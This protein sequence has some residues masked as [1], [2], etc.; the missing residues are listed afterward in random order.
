V[1]TARQGERRLRRG[2][3]IAA[4]S[5]LLLVGSTF[6]QWFGAEPGPYNTLQLIVLLGYG[7]T[8]WQ[9]LDLLP[10]FLT[11]VALFALGAA[12]L[13]MRGSRW[14]PAVPLSA[15]V[16]VFGGLAALLVLVQIVFPPDY[17]AIEH[18]AIKTNLEAGAFMALL[19]SCGVAYGGYRA[20]GEEGDS[21]EAIAERLSNKRRVSRASD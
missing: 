12:V 21:F 5:A 14:R 10:W 15:G 4:A 11:L 1:S 8:A 20:M 17:G 3:A 18:V 16:A 7:G 9:S 2:E 13:G 6:L 19:A